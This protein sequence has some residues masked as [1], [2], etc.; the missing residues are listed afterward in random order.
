MSDNATDNRVD[1]PA[2]KHAL[3]AK[4]LGWSGFVR[5][6][7]C[8][9]HWRHFTNEVGVGHA[10]PNSAASHPLEPTQPQVEAMKDAVRESEPVLATPNRV[11]YTTEDV[12]QVAKALHAAFIGTPYERWSCWLDARD[13]ITLVQRITEERTDG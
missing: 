13:I 7:L 5:C 4:R 9:H 2:C 10:I 12:E 8:G 11:P 3:S 1:C 6:E